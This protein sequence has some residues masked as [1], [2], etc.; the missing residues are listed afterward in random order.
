MSTVFNA[1][2]ILEMAVRIE[3]NG[4]KFYR[5]AAEGFTNETA[6]KTLLD[7]AVMEDGHEKTFSDM[8]GKLSAGEQAPT[9]FDPDGEAAGYLQAMA[10]GHVFD[11]KTDPSEAL[12]GNESWRDIIKIAIELEKNSII[13][14]TGIREFVPENLGR[15]KIGDII[16]EEMGHV[17]L[18]TTAL[19]LTVE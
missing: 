6:K 7:L 17:T 14:Y 16:R 13:F 18:L 12:T 9:I 10:D 5:C 19:K 4:A 15:K 3:Q 1:N 8:K 2:E 11:V